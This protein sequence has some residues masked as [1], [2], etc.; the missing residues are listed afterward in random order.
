MR[1]P[2]GGQTVKSIVQRVLVVHH[3]ADVRETTREMMQRGKA[4]LSSASS[5]ALAAAMLTNEDYDL[6]LIDAA[7]TDLGSIELA[8]LAA[9]ENVATLLLSADR[10]MNIQLDRYG[11]PYLREPFSWK[12]LQTASN[13]A[14]REAQINILKVKAAVGRM[15]ANA[16]ALSV[17]VAGSQQLIEEILARLNGAGGRGRL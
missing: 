14:V 8:T 17:D 2:L 15:I 12:E 11:F 10:A 9:N 7:L 3:D 1:S 16:T 5:G 13:R 4:E 6:A